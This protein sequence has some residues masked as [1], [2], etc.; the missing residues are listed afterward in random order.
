MKNFNLYE[1][2]SFIDDDILEQSEQKSKKILM[3]NWKKWGTL[4]ACCLIMIAAFA[5][6]NLPTSSSPD[7][8]QTNPDGNIKKYGVS[9]TDTPQPQDIT[10]ASVDTQDGTKKHPAS[11]DTEDGAKKRP[12][13]AIDETLTLFEAQKVK[14]LGAYMLSKGPSDFSLESIQHYQDD[15][16]NYLNELWTKGGDSFDEISWRVSLYD[17][18]YANYITS[19]A[20]TKNYDL[21]LYPFPLADSVPEELFGIVEHPIFHIEE[22]TLDVVNRR[23]YSFDNDNDTNEIRMSFGVLYD[24][25]VVE[26]TTKG[27]SSKWLYEQLIKLKT[28]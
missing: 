3:Y 21:S 13:N 17:E 2:F 22:L 1:S 12:T 9:D 8:P 5:M 15:T 26:V 10:Q 20:D 18:T 24:D 19:V 14:Y 16:S 25:I 28:R 7:K 23:A 6:P 27:I 11:T 4:V